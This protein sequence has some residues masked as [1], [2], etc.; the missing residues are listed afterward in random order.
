VGTL[1]SDT[2][3]NSTSP[4][5]G[6][7]FDFELF[8]KVGLTFDF[9]VLWQ[10]DPTVSLSSDG[11]LSGLQSFLDDL[12]TERAELANEVA[13]FKAYPVLSLGFN[14]NF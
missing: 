12:A 11:T 6:A 9:G 14:F 13:V 1:S 10:G 2:S 5:V 8:G 4:Y 3:W 7:G